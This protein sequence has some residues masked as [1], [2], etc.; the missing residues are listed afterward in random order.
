MFWL[1]RHARLV[2]AENTI[3]VARHNLMDRISKPSR[4]YATDSRPAPD[5]AELSWH[6]KDCIRAR[7]RIFSG[8]VMV[9]HDVDRVEVVRIHTM[10]R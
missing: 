5:T 3:A 1:G 8:L 6:V 7:E 10:S 2:L 4:Q 9:F